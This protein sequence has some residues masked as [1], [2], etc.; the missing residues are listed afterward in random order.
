ML[1][2]RPEAILKPFNIDCDMV[3]MT[4]AS[5]KAGFGPNSTDG[6]DGLLHAV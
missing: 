6:D 1:T 4:D 2:V 5:G 3:I